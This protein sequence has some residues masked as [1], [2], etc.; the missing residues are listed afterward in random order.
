MD[1]KRRKLF[2]LGGVA[3]AAVV[4]ILLLLLMQTPGKPPIAPDK[5]CSTS[6]E[7]NLYTCLGRP[8]GCWNS[9]RQETCP[10][11]QALE[12]PSM[13]YQIL[14][15]HSYCECLD[16]A[17][18][19]KNDVEAACLELCEFYSNSQIPSNRE[20]WDKN[21]PGRTCGAFVNAGAGEE[22]SKGGD[23][24]VYLEP[25]CGTSYVCRNEAPSA[26]ERQVMCKTANPSMMTP[27]YCECT[28][29]GCMARLLSP[30]TCR[31]YCDYWTSQ[32]CETA[33]TG[34]QLAAG[35]DLF[36]SASW[37][38]N[39]PNTACSC[40]EDALR[41]VAVRDYHDCCEQYY[42]NQTA[43]EACLADS[44][45]YT[46]YKRS[47]EEGGG[48]IRL[49]YASPFCDNATSDA[50]KPCKTAHDCEGKCLVSWDAEGDNLTGR[51]SLWEPEVGAYAW[52]DDDEKVQG[53]FIEVLTA[54]GPLPRICTLDGGKP[55]KTAYDCQGRCLVDSDAEG[56]NLTGRCS[57]WWSD[58]QNQAWLGQDG[59]KENY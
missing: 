23:C 6:S 22:C 28:P 30:G 37:G 54:A 57:A 18:V 55:C 33:L 9:P 27:A 56:D 15:R 41:T 40:V 31:E 59:E 5:A 8:K 20:F 36:S 34:A 51:C 3:A 46:A 32:N 4:I 29:S 7:C 16:G 10:T 50:G 43:G 49:R 2:I 35:Y 48:T 25:C 45:S 39:C 53:A 26:C 19:M 42:L 11:G 21:C 1:P 24:A 38:A 47:C 12:P 58:F 44:A 52:L 14:W 17:C 13:D